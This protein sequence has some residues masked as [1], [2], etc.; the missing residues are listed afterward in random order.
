MQG[1]SWFYPGPFS[2]LTVH[3]LLTLAYLWLWP[4]CHN[5]QITPFSEFPSPGSCMQ[6]ATEL[7]SLDISLAFR[8]Q[9]AQTELPTSSSN[10][11]FLPHCISVCITL[12]LP[13]ILPGNLECILTLPFLHLLYPIILPY[14]FKSF[15]YIVNGSVA[16]SSLLIS[17][18][19]HCALSPGYSNYLLIGLSLFN[20]LCNVDILPFKS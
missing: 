5:K 10:Q 11:V 7:F 1:P 4:H 19:S 9:H 20:F 3:Y 12:I 18:T 17:C 6:M 15:K 14:W 16:P 8:T 13:H 2:L